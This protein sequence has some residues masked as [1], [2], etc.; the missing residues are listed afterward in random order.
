MTRQKYTHG[1]S[2]TKKESRNILSFYFLFENQA[3]TNIERK[4]F[5]FYLSLH[6]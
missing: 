2:E 1:D 4:L 3:I 5:E 6:P